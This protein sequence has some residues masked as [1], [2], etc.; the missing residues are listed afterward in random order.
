MLSSIKLTN[1]DPRE[2][3]S[4]VPLHRAVVTGILAR[5]PKAAEEAMGAHLEDTTARLTLAVEGFSVR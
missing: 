3:E 1:A 4:S 5:D 2:N